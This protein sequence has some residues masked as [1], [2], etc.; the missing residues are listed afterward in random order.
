MYNV[1]II[2]A[3]LCVNCRVRGIRISGSEEVSLLLS[4]PFTQPDYIKC[5]FGVT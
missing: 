3:A 4:L 5:I 2:H 1:H